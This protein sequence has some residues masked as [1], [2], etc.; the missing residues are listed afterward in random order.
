MVRLHQFPQPT[1]GIRYRNDNIAAV[2]DSK[3]LG[4]GSL[5]ITEANI[6]WI[7][8]TS[9]EG[10]SILYP[11]MTL[12][13]ISKDE[14]INPNP[15]LYIM[16]NGYLDEDGPRQAEVE[17]DEGSDEGAACD[18][19]EIITEVRFV[20]QGDSGGILETIYKTVQECT[21]LHPDPSSDMSDDIDEGEEGEEDEE[22]EDEDE[23]EDADAGFGRLMERFGLHRNAE[24][25][26]DDEPEHPDQFKDA[27]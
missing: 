24:G 14:A 7:N 22:D 6:S 16:L 8:G 10:F 21:M 9:G 3:E 13:A 17:P 2:V 20:P 23:Y 12:H 25:Q 26:G 27:D 11:K 18:A 15:C 4:S 5:Y 1:D 19:E